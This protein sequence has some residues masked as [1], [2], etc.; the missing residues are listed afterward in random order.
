MSTEHC[1]TFSFR[2]LESILYLDLELESIL[3]KHKFKKKIKNENDSS[4]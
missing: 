1:L 3:Y 4:T 2:K